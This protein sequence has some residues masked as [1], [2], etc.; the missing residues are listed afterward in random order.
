MRPNLAFLL[1]C[2]SLLPLANGQD[3]PN[4]RGPNWDG[5][6]SVEAL[7]ASFSLEEGIA[8]SLDLP[9]PGASTPVIVGD[10]IFLTSVQPEEGKLLDMKS[11]KMLKKQK[12]KQKQTKLI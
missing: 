3:W 1:L 11:K 6:S 12:Q 8:W 5:S 4:W 7:P 9:G 2:S 10:R